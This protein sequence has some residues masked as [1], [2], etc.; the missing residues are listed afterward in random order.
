M[1]TN[2][3]NFGNLWSLLKL[4]CTAIVAVKY[5]KKN[6]FSYFENKPD[7]LFHFCPQLP[8]PCNLFCTGLLHCA[9]ASSRNRGPAYFLQ[10][11]TATPERRCK[12][13]ASKLGVLQWTS[14][15]SA[16]NLILHGPGTCKNLSIQVWLFLEWK[17]KCF[18][19]KNVHIT[20]SYHN[21]FLG[22]QMRRLSND[23]NMVR[24]NHQIMINLVYIKIKPSGPWFERQQHNLLANKPAGSSI[25]RS[26]VHSKVM[27]DLAMRRHG[28]NDWLELF[29]DHR[30]ILCSEGY[31][32]LSL[33]SKATYIC[34]YVTTGKWPAEVGE[35]KVTSVQICLFLWFTVLWRPLVTAQIRF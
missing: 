19:I 1:V 31:P 17:T 32:L 29:A 9:P 20:D 34:L 10:I 13:H 16:L 27:A 22:Q 11:A 4:V 5:N 30:F 12:A 2:L 35:H 25:T 21:H 24:L 28:N 8:V 26:A 33:L 6:F 18:K 15:S 7:V 3:N 14:P 23:L